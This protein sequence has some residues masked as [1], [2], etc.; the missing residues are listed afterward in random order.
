MAPNPSDNPNN[1]ERSY[2]SRPGVQ[3]ITSGEAARFDERIAEKRN[4]NNMTSRDNSCSSLNS[5]ARTPR[6]VPDADDRE[7][8][9]KPPARPSRQESDM[10]TQNRFMAGRPNIIVDNEEDVDK[11]MEN[12]DMQ[13]KRRAKGSRPETVVPRAVSFNDRDA[14]TV[15]RDIEAKNQSWRLSH[16]VL[17]SSVAKKPPGKLTP[18]TV[19]TSTNNAMIAKNQVRSRDGPAIIP[20]VLEERNKN[21]SDADAVVKN[22]ARSRDGPAMIPG[23]FEERTNRDFPEKKDVAFGRNDS[24]GRKLDA[25]VLAKRNAIDGGANAS[26][27]FINL[28]DDDDC[29]GLTAKKMSAGAES[30]DSGNQ[31]KKTVGTLGLVYNYDAPHKGSTV[32]RPPEQA[33][34]GGENAGQMDVGFMDHFGFEDFDNELAIAKP[35][36]EEEFEDAFIPA[37]VEYDPDSKPPTHKSRRVRIFGF[38]TLAVVLGGIAAIVTVLQLNQDR[39]DEGIGPTMAP[40]VYRESLGIQEQIAAVVGNAIYQNGTAHE[41]A[42]DWLLYDDPLQLPPDA[43]NLLQ[44]YLL[45]LFHFQTTEEGPWRSCNPPG[46]NETAVCDFQNIVD[47]EPLLF[48]AVPGIRWLSEKSECEWSG[49]FCEPNSLIIRGLLLSKYIAFCRS[50]Q[51]SYLLAI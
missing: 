37:A 33:V 18:A 8:N 41:K 39:D 9:L 20:H 22:Q 5:S 25:D 28:E 19:E 50:K 16:M 34:F 30:A 6:Q 3:H 43:E 51:G 11:L 23:V 12:N 42:L 24:D 1:A 21:T 47:V 46:D 36:I 4:K 7:M 15:D 32:R 31:D 45:T 48:E 17:S 44:R 38:L 40:T 49:V 26:R 2:A 14:A 35:V 10:L 13:A 27:R 29:N